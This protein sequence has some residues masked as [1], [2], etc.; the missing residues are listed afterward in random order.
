MSLLDTL[1]TFPQTTKQPVS[2]EYHGVQVVDEYQ[3]LENVADPNVQ[4]WIAD[5]NQYS[6]AVFDAIPSRQPLAKRC[7]EILT[8]T[9]AKFYSLKYCGKRLFAMKYQPPKQ[10]A[11]LVTLNSPNDLASE[12]VVLDPMTINPDAALS[13]DFYQPSPDGRLVAV[14]LSE[15]GSEKG[16]VHL[17]DVESGQALGD[18]IPRVN[19]PTAGGSVAWTKDA[20]GL[21]Y[22]RYPAPG[23]RPPEDLDF[24]QQVYFHR[25]GQPI[26]EDTYVFG[27]DLPRIA[28]I[29]LAMSEDGNSLLV[30]VKNG[31]GGEHAHYLRN[32]NGEW[33]QITRFEDE[34]TDAEFGDDKLYLLSYKGTLRGKVLQLPLATPDLSQAQTLIPERETSIRTIIPTDQ[35]L[36]LVELD[37]GPSHITIFGMNGAE[38]GSIPTLPVSSI[39]Q[40]LPLDGDEILFQSAS[41]IQPPAWYRFTPSEEEPKQTALFVT[42]EVDTTKLAVKRM[43]ATSKDGTKVP[44]NI[45]HHKTIEL[46]GENPTMLTGYGGY[47]IS[48]SPNF[49]IHDFPFLEQG[50]V[51][52]IANLRGG[53]EFGE[54]WHR[55]GNL[56][57][58]QNVFDDFIACA[59]TLIASGYTKPDKLSITGGSNGGLLMGAVLTQR[60]DLFRAVIAYVGVLDMLRVEL[61]PNGAFNITEYGTVKSREQFR[62]LY[63]YSPYHHVV[64][65]T[66]YPTVLFVTGDNDGRVN[67]AHSRKMTARLQ[68]ATSSNL[69]ILLRTSS[70]SGHGFGTSLDEDIAESADTWAFLFEA[71]GM[72]YETATP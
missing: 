4:R 66:A 3:W 31:D 18:V 69:P 57:N 2:N 7:W 67:P 27:K 35:Q 65:G 58:K 5:Q 55:G 11:F 15:Y 41:Y 64:D 22:T 26:S 62:A 51:I 23:E 17:Y 24:Y 56:T 61:D 33:H 44:L 63:A 48:L 40:V 20:S 70:T 39:G 37:G 49:R 72:S 46:N 29:S 54:A 53:G 12:H 60:P 50:G 28:E 21:Y 34:I 8:Q 9:S 19:N 36:Y 10:Q 38:Q 68:A 71:L 13:I 14:S 52:A 16:T 30:T 43:Y 25:L 6:R 59:E 45:L 1:S 32:A 47:G 42:P